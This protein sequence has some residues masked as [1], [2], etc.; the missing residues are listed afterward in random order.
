[1][2]VLGIERVDYVSKKSGNQVKGAYL[3]LAYDSKRIDGRGVRT[4]FIGEEL[5]SGVALGDDI[6]L[7][8]NQY[9]KVVQISHI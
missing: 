9:R 6:E 2:Q 8:Y 1:M 4:E 3:H 5:A 7:L